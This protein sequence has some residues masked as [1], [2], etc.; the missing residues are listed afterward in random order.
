MLD[1]KSTN[2]ILEYMLILN[3]E[4]TLYKFVNPI[5]CYDIDDRIFAYQ[6]SKLTYKLIFNNK[7]TKF[8]KVSRIDYK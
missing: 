3:N 8:E 6:N 4:L 1:A 2:E 5:L 7:I